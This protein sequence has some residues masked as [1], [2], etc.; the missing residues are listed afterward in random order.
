MP[1]EN[2]AISSR[3]GFAST[4][5]GNLLTWDEERRKLE[6]AAETARVVWG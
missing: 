6:L 3:C 5:W 2:L 1:L 4:R